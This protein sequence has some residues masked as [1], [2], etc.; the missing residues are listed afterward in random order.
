MSSS[1]PS[2]TNDRAAKPCAADPAIALAIEDEIPRFLR[3]RVFW[4]GEAGPKA[5]GDWSVRV[6][7]HLQ[8]RYSETRAA[9]FWSMIA[10]FAG[11]AR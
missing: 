3:W 2:D 10:A 7:E 9:V 5:I 6:A 1:A 8:S 4:C 11:H